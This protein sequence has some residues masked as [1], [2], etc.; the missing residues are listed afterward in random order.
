MRKGKSS[1]LNAMI[2][3]D[4]VI[5]SDIPGATGR[6]L[7]WSHFDGMP[8]LKR[9]HCLLS[10]FMILSACPAAPQPDP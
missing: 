7:S 3:E 1:L 9:E 5:V 6:E 2:G 8:A 10:V 4:R